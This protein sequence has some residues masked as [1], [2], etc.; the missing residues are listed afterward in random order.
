M[1]T[2]EQAIRN[3]IATWM[4]ATKAGDVETV[5]SLMTDDVVFLVPGHEP[6]RKS[7][8]AAAAKAQLAP[9]APKFEGFSEIEEVKIAGEWAF[10][11]TKLRVVV[12]PPGAGS[13]M[14]RAGYTLTVL[15]KQNG[16]WLLARDANLLGPVP[17]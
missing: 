9:G 13:T 11:R 1:Q 7:G 15:Q 2:D 3:L 12:T 6:M 17:K 8:F 4:A 16:R 5:L 14:E 10:M